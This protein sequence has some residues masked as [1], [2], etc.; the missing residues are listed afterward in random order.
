MAKRGWEEGWPVYPW[1]EPIH[2]VI[3]R[4][5]REA[6]ERKRAEDIEAAR[7]AAR[8]KD[9]ATQ[10]A[11]KVRGEEARMVAAARINVMVLLNATGRMG[12]ALQSL[13]DQ[14]SAAIIDKKVPVDEMSGLLKNVA[15]AA[16]A[17]VKAGQVA[18]EVERLF[19]GDPTKIIGVQ[20][21][22]FTP[23]EAYEEI[24]AATEVAQRWQK[25]GNLTLVV[26]K[27]DEQAENTGAA[28]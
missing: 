20:D 3:E 8:V 21:T 5:Q 12:P 26:S 10:E 2:K 19:R 13:S 22:N 1:A 17:T 16:A 11:I 25:R 28:R 14:I 7:A 6:Q 9:D 23:D 15:S 24:M 18:L 27:G 4:K